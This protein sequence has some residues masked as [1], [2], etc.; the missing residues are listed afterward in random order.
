MSAHDRTPMYGPTNFMLVAHMN[1]AFGNPK[2]FTTSIDWNRIA[3]QCLNIADELAE[4]FVALGADKAEAKK[5]SALFKETLET[6]RQQAKKP[7]NVNDVRD[8]ITDIHVFSYGAHHLMGIDA[9]RDMSSVIDGVMTR[10]IKDE[11][12]L[13]ASIELHASNGITDVYTEGEFPT[14]I[15]KSG[16][17]QPDAPKGKF[18]KSASYH[19][20]IFYEI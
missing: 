1:N 15:L 16:S 2:G 3:K 5:A 20:P 11:A 13:K 4:T 19:E 12:D 8:G 10:F 14:M 7:V 9:D 18:L 17:D 6:L